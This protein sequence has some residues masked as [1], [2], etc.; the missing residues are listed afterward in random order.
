MNAMRTVLFLGSLVALGCQ[1]PVAQLVAQISPVDDTL[2]TQSV[3]AEVNF[4]DFLQAA[5]PGGA[6][7][8]LLRLN[9]TNPEGD[10]M[11]FI[12]TPVSGTFPVGRYS[13][14][15]NM[16]TFSSVFTAGGSK[17]TVQ[18]DTISDNFLNIQSITM[19]G[20]L[21]QSISGDFA[22]NFDIGGSGEGTINVT[23]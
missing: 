23:N 13:L 5:P 7:S 16:N 9:F 20:G 14:D 6:Q 18:A 17:R 1:N 8:G 10:S 22:M 19:T 21:V 12:L 2:G 3:F 11:D 4:T 15:G